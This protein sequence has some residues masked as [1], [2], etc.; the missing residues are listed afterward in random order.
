SCDLLV[1]TPRPAPAAGQGSARVRPAGL[2]RG[3]DG[4]RHR[5]PAC[6]AHAA[7][8]HRRAERRRLA[9]LRLPSAPGGADRALQPRHALDRA[10]APP[11]GPRV[12]AVPHGA[13]TRPRV[14]AAMA[15]VVAGALA[16]APALER[17]FPGVAAAPTQLPGTRRLCAP[18]L[19]A[20]RALPA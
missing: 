6:A 20:V 11:G 3:L 17:F 19:R 2:R 1:G 10:A 14:V 18:A 13:R 16:P 15:G 7:G 12:V 4:R 8:R 9:L 5:P